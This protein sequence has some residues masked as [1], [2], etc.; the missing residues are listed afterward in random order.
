MISSNG[1]VLKPGKDKAIRQRHHWIFSG[2]IERA[3]AF[4]NGDILPVYSANGQL[5][6]SAY[7]NHHSSIMGRMVAFDAKPPLEAIE[8]NMQEAL[9]LRQRF[10]DFEQTN[11]YR[12][13][14]GEGDG[15]PGLIVDVYDQVVVLQS[16]THGIECLKSWIVEWIQTH[17]KPQGIYEKSILPSRKEEKLQEQQGILKGTIS[18]E[19]YFKENGL[20]FTTS[21][22]KSQKTGFFLDHREMR[23]WIGELSEGKRVL[24]A[25]SYTGGF[26]VYA[27]A[28]GATKVDSVDISADAIEVAKKHVKLNKIGKGEAGFFTENVFEFLRNRETLPYDIVILDPPAFAKKKKDI[29]PACRGYKDINRLA[30][31]K[32]PPQSLLL[33]CSCSHYVE[34]ALFQKVLFQAAAE[35]N[36]EVKIVGKHRLAFDHPLN[37]FHPESQYLKSFLLF[38]N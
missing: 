36:R 10:I 14:N 11:A 4:Q 38:V 2:A 8:R 16:S 5:L 27:L 3:P 25:F 20:V 7:F 9:K 18:E 19:V 24:N 21:L 30:M 35:A 26:S 31:Q 29:V 12:L 17:L 28:G 32:M 6:G 13:I 15:I 23:K 33:T 1:V 37:L 34:E 22:E